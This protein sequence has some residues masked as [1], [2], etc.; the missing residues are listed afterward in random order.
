MKKIEINDREVFE[1]YHVNSI[2]NSEYQFSTLFIWQ[3]A[4]NFEYEV[5]NDCLIVYGTQRNGD[6]QVYFPIGKVDDLDS[7]VGHIKHIFGDL[8][9]NVNIRPLSESMKERLL[10]FIDFDIEVGSKESYSDYIYDY[11][12]LKNYSGSVYKKKRHELHRFCSRYDYKYESIDSENA[13]EVLEALD[14]ILNLDSIRD[15]EEYGAYCKI[16]GNFESLNLR[17]GIIKI[18]G[19]IEAVSIGEAIGSMVLMHL[20]RC[21][22][23]FE[24]IYPAMLHFVLNSEFDNTEYKI[25]NTQDDMGNENI[26]RTKLSYN[27]VCVYRKYFVKEVDNGK[28]LC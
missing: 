27:P 15:E 9:Q 26:R 23:C 4:Y 20:R 11:I 1:R 25:V 8:N 6:T 13:K 12:P 5:W 24:G 16:L 19:I 28:I 18:N 7:Y 14:R 21:N 3:H 10:H 22:K 17:G 2:I